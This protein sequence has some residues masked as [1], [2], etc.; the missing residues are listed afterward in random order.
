[1]KGKFKKYKVLIPWIFALVFFVI[2]IYLFLQ[3]SH[4]DN[5]INKQEEATKTIQAV[6]KLMVLPDEVPTVATVTDLEK[7]KDQVF[8]KNA[9]IGDKVLIYLK[10]QKAILYDSESNKIIELAPLNTYNS[11]II[12][13]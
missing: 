12:K 10:A 8:F 6:G 5:I 7:L 2:A 3:L 1:M 4:K 9:K 13:N 11:L